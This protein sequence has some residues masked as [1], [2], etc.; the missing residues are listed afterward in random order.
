M[1][2]TGEHPV[3]DLLLISK[4]LENRDLQIIRREDGVLRQGPV[5]RIIR[6]RPLT[7]TIE[8]SWLAEVIGIGQWAV[9]NNAPRVLTLNEGVDTAFMEDDRRIVINNLSQG[10]TAYILPEGQKLSEL[11]AAGIEFK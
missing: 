2:V 11:E 8:V 3:S 4:E 9:D 6:P 10:W 1:T 5:L 7:L